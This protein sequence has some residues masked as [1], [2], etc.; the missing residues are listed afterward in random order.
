[1]F[2][3]IIL[4]LP[5]IIS[6]VMNLFMNVSVETCRDLPFIIDIQIASE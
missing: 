2:G 5:F 1:M 4:F 6:R 3:F